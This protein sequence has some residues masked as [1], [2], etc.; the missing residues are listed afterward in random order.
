M[1]CDIGLE[2]L[3]RLRERLDNSYRIACSAEFLNRPI[4]MLES[5]RKSLYNEIPAENDWFK[6]AFDEWKNIYM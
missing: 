6:R 2:W 1:R 4:M 3:E 5:W